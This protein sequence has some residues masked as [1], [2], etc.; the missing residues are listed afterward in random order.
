MSTTIKKKKKKILE[1]DLTLITTRRSCGLIR[2]RLAASH[3]EW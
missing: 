3:G 1:L 2:K